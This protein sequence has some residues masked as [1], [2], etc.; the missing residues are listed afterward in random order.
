ERR[1]VITG[2]PVLGT[3]FLIEIELACLERFQRDAEVAVVVH[4]DAVEIVEALAHRQLR[5]PVIGYPLEGHGAARTNLTYAVGT[6]AQWRLET[7][8][9]EITALPVMLGQHRQLAEHQRQ[10]A[11]APVEEMKG[12]AVFAVGDHLLYIAIIGL[13][14]GGSFLDQGVEGEHHVGSSDRM[15]IVE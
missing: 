6:T 10:L 2:A 12:D 7:V 5:R 4:R 11:I 9:V 8:A 3:V 15:A 1:A 13:V 14:E